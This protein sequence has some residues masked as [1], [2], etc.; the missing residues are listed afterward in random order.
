MA[1]PREGPMTAKVYTHLGLE[2]LRGSVEAVS[3]Q[4]RGCEATG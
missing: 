3:E 4:R 1:V 2:D